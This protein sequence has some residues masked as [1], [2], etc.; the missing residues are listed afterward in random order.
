MQADPNQ[1]TDALS[2]DKSQGTPGGV[3]L[4]KIFTVSLNGV[5]IPLALTR[6]ALQDFELQGLEVM[7]EC[8]FQLSE[9]LTPANA[10][11]LCP[12][13]L[14]LVG[15]M[16][17]DGANS[18]DTRKIMLCALW[19]GHHYPALSG[20]IGAGTSHSFVHHTTRHRP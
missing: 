19:L 13:P 4:I 8:L 6:K 16:I 12:N 3:P 7:D 15:Q 20:L 10:P 18:G 14:D 17:L 1:T 11:H 5:E 9:R 2:L